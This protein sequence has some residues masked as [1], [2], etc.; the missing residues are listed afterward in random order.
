MNILGGNL[1]KLIINADDLGLTHESNLGIT[2]ALKMGYCTQ[3]TF[4][5]NSK[6]SD[7]GANL[8]FKNKFNH[9]VGLHLNLSEEMPLTEKIKDLK[10]YV[11]K[12]KLNYYPAYMNKSSYGISPLKTYFEEYTNLEF[13][14]EIEAV[15]EELEAQI[16]KFID[17]GFEPN[18]IDSHSN[19]LMDLPVW[20]ALKPLLLKYKFKSIRTVFDSFS[21][22][23]LYNKIYKEWLKAEISSL[24]MKSTSYSS[25]IQ[26]YMKRKDEIQD[27]KILELYIHPIWKRQQLIDNFTNGI[28]IKDNFS[29]I[30]ELETTSFFQL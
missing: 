21:N 6:F 19:I 5:V 4:V 26:R 16:K 27:L 3:T 8:S 29:L 30:K 10:K 13:K 15:R 2:K 28:L 23:D 18:H 17:Y 25:S 14:M 11:N 22:N 12:G 24:G 1:M 7:E 20:L 9:L